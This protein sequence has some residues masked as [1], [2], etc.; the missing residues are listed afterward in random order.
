[1]TRS[2]QRLSGLVLAF[3]SASAWVPA[4]ARGQADPARFL[5]AVADASGDEL[6]RLSDGVPLIKTLETHDD[7]ELAQA[8]VVRVRA[9]VSFILE[10]IRDR[11]LL[12]DDADGEAGR[13]IFGRPPR[14]EDLRNLGFPRA[15]IRDLERCR[16]R[17]CDVKLPAG[18]AERLHREVDWESDTARE[19][20]NRFL[21]ELL[22]ETLT[23][24][25]DA[26]ARVVYEDKGEPLAV[27]EGFEKLFEE[28]GALNELDGVF[29]EH[30]R[31]FPESRAQGVEDLYSWTVE[32]LGTKSLVSLN[33][34]AI[35]ERSE[36]PG[37]SI[38]GIK[39]FYASHYFQ[40]AV[41]IIT[42]SPASGDPAAPDTYVTVLARFRFDGELGGLKRIATE[43]RLERN[44]EHA[45]SDVRERLES[46]HRQ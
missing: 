30:L 41:R 16:P 1:M 3:G 10:Q 39:R 25:T 6:A 13:G 20:A 43:R 5:R 42:L 21:R 8:Y 17:R 19:D 31:R 18:S 27:E 32:D 33:H 23:T 37:T 4:S 26:G 7:R 24:Y 11:H 46:L 40:A 29:H 12:L 45:M 34:I 38:I 15:A 28:T 14:P 35:R 2:I 44:A 9:P 22:L 36:T